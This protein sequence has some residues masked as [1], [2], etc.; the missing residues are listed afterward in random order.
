MYYLSKFHVFLFA[1]IVVLTAC[2]GI[3]PVQKPPVE[4]PK[5]AVIWDLFNK[6]EN[7]DKI[8]VNK[9]LWHASLDV[10]D[11]LPLESVDPYKGIIVT[12]WGAAPGSSK[13]YKVIVLITDA[14][15]DATSLTLS[16]Q[17]VNGVPSSEVKRQVEN[18][19][20]TRAR[21]LRISGVK[22]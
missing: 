2:D 4:E 1:C 19:I 18:A 5:R 22:L 21:Q 6:S 14:A 3:K 10:L 9:Y 17:S 11:F 8:E 13:K 15:L 16:I 12:G 7:S 20:L